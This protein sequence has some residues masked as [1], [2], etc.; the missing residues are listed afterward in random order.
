MNRLQTVLLFA[1]RPR[2]LSVRT[3]KGIW[4]VIIA[5][6]SRMVARKESFGHMKQK[7]R[8]STLSAP[9]ILRKANFRYQKHVSGRPVKN[10]MLCVGRNISI[11]A[12][13]FRAASGITS[14]A[15]RGLRCFDSSRSLASQ[16]RG[17]G[18][19]SNEFRTARRSSSKLLS[20]RWAR[21]FF[22]SEP[23]IRPN[24]RSRAVR[25]GKSASTAGKRILGLVGR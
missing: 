17:V 18:V 5:R 8:E 7:T 25:T 15:P 12:G 19:S 2:T 23:F 24:F 13:K 20:G 11:I 10:P 3:R 6:T 1:A 4:K 22:Q 16:P 9:R 21:N 14:V